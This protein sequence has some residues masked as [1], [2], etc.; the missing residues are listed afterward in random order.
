[1]A[2]HSI[3]GA[4]LVEPLLGPEIAQAVLRHHERVDGK[5]YPSRLSGQ[6]IPFASRVVQIC[7]AWVAMTSAHSYQV[8]ID[9]TEAVKRMREGAGSQFD[10]ELVAKFLDSLGEITDL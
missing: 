3:V 9:P 5:G 2:E 8:S 4:A 7:D 6:Q 1:M 10:Q